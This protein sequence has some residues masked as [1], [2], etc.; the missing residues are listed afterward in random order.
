[1]VNH[2][3][4]E[5]R[6]DCS[7]QKFSKRIRSLLQLKYYDRSS[8]EGTTKLEGPI[9]NHFTPYGLNSTHVGPDHHTH[10]QNATIFLPSISFFKLTKNE[11]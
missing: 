2:V 5:N 8:L 7:I 10:D 1:M 6:K 11:T 9:S 4:I 3:P